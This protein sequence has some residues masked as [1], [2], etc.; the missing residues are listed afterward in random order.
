[1]ENWKN[2]INPSEEVRD[3]VLEAMM[4]DSNEVSYTLTKMGMPV[5]STDGRGDTVLHG[6]IS[7]LNGRSGDDH[8][9]I[10]ELTLKCGARTDV[11]NKDGMTQLDVA[12]KKWTEGEQTSII[13]GPRTKM[14]SLVVQATLQEPT[15]YGSDHVKKASGAQAELGK[16]NM[17]RISMMDS[18][19]IGGNGPTITMPMKDKVRVPHGRADSRK[20]TLR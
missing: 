2:V 10:V 13:A 14:L 16:A 15:R 5:D 20:I 19:S 18:M 6:A 9:A 8:V 4:G 7:G 17:E 11:A 3:V 1:M 12:V